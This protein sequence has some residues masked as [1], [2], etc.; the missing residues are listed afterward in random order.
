MNSQESGACKPLKDY[1]GCVE[2]QQ[3]LCSV[4]ENDLGTIS[5]SMKQRSVRDLVKRTQKGT[6]LIALLKVLFKGCVTSSK[7]DG[8]TFA[9]SSFSLT[10]QL[11]SLFCW[12][13]QPGLVTV[14]DIRSLPCSTLI[15]NFEQ[16]ISVTWDTNSPPLSEWRMCGHPNCLKIEQRPLTTSMAC[17]LLSSGSGNVSKYLFRKAKWFANIARLFPHFSN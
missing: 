10:Q 15:F 7:S 5:F 12:G 6:S 4:M 8:Q 9:W 13:F 11:F 14:D 17:L 1:P 2:A 16:R 3:F